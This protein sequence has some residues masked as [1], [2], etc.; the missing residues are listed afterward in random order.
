MPTNKL[1]DC[2]L[3]YNELEMLK[4]R[5]EYLYDIVDKFVLVECTLTFSG[6][7]KQLY[8]QDNKHLFEKYND[9][10]IH[11]IV[12]NLPDKTVAQDAWVR[13]KMHRNSI[14]I[15]LQQLQLNVKDLLIIC[16][17]DEIPDR[18]TLR[19]MQ[20]SRIANT[21]YALEQ[22][23]YYYNLTCRANSK[24]YHAKLVNYY[25]YKN[26]YKS[27]S[28]NI[29]LTDKYTKLKNGGWHFSYFGD[30]N[31][32]K[33]KIQNFA[34]QEFNN[35]TYLND[36]KIMQQIQT[37]GDLYFRDIE[38]SYCDINDNKYLPE[39]YQ[40]LLHFSELYANK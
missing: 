34:H 24:W 28:D 4:F 39:N 27:V 30:I 15:G 32:I 40:T 3:F 23:L 21:V 37:C 20:S 1:I 9:K 19:K 36:T 16:D 10:I 26:I 18:N 5:L 8:Y 7:A 29:R 38:Y 11:V 33:N 12:T 6:N 14:D 25:T 17:L 35:D 2:F 13:E 22:D 31:F